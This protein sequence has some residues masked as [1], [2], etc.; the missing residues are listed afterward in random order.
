MMHFTKWAGCAIFLTLS[1]GS[2]A[3]TSCYQNPSIEGPSAPHVVPAPWQACY[4]SPDT[5]PGQWG[6]TQ[7]P[8][9]GNSYVSF[10]QSGWSSG[11]YTEGMTQ[12]LVPCMVAGTTYSF[13]VDLAHTPI[14]NT[15]D[16]NGCYS[17]FI[18]YGGATACA[19]TEIL[20]TSGSF[21]HTNWQT[22][23]VTFTPTGNWCYLSFAPYFI[24]T[25]GSTG[26]DYI[27]VMVDN[28]TC[29]QPAGPI[30]NITSPQQNDSMPCGFLVT[31]TFD[32]IPTQVVLSGAFINSPIL[33]TINGNNFYAN[34]SYPQGMSGNTTI[35]ATAT[36]PDS[37]T[38]VDS[39]TFNLID[40]LPA[41][42]APA[43][44]VGDPTVFT[45]QSTI[46]YGSIVGW[47]WNF[48]D[49][50]TSTLQNPTHTYGAP[51]TYTVTLILTSDSACT[52][53]IQQTVLVHGLPNAAITS[54]NVC[55]GQTMNF[56]S[57]NSTS[58]DGSI[59]GWAWDFGE[60]ASGPNNNSLLANPSHTYL[61]AG[62]FT[63]TLVI[64][65][66]YGCTDSVTQ[67]VTVHSNPVIAFTAD[68]LEG[69]GPLCVNF[70]DQTT[71]TN[72]TIN[73]WQWNF[74]DG[75]TANS[76]APVHCFNQSGLFTITLTATSAFGCTSTDSVVQMINVYPFPVAAFSMSPQP[77]TISSPIITF[78]DSSINTQSWQWDFADP[79]D[80]VTNTSTVQHPIHT[81]SDSGVYCPRL[82]VNNG[83]CTDTLIQCLVID[84]EL[85][86]YIPN[87][88]TP[89]GD[90][91][92][93]I[94]LP[95]GM[96]VED[97]EMIIFD[98]WGNQIY[99]TNDLYKGWDGRV[100]GKS[101]IVQIDTYVYLIRV[102][103]SNNKRHVYRGHVNVVR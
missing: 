1:I 35:Y 15:A 101:D 50:T 21:T 97:F 53:S 27:N 59:T 45:D 87:T 58:T 17:S 55:F 3:Q 28:I 73:V 23:T 25:C 89:N 56:S 98:R 14:Y 88:F 60:P 70:S 76:I 81:Y 20:W 65:T 40:I 19:Q 29:V 64:S 90:N 48:G 12:L 6:I 54:T 63:V 42:S 5:Q 84:P 78:T 57:A 26:F 2:N 86:F 34:V 33:A 36:Y 74:G 67:T 66:Q 18:V 9:N 80:L 79:N 38:K 37:T 83:F 39:V 85:S 8:S 92:N 68:T 47:N 30:L 103:D 75:G 4:G 41:F 10:L 100:Q 32:T 82:V 51:G 62:T 44:C 61:S 93:D 77:T 95:K 49:N 52:D 71:V 46:T 96:Y 31:G 99:K 16:P 24:T 7:A 22:Y 11:G 69:C 43:V 72:S 102:L 13:N 91:K 94:F